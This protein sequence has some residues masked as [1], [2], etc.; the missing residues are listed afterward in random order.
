[1]S[2]QKPIVEAFAAGRSAEA[3]KLLDDLH[4]RI[5][6]HNAETAFVR[7]KNTERLHDLYLSDDV[8]GQM[9]AVRVA[10]AAVSAAVDRRSGRDNQEMEKR[11]AMHAANATL[12][13]TMR[14][15]MDQR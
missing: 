8:R 13:R 2:S 4:E 9:H 6:Y 3:A 7:A 1:M 15:E 14:D 12:F 5:L 11:D 10:M